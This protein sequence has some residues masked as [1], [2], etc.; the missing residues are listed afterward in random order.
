MVFKGRENSD[1][2]YSIIGSDLKCSAQDPS[3]SEVDSEE[4]VIT[5]SI[6]LQSALIFTGF[7]AKSCLLIVPHN[8][9]SSDICLQ[10][11]SSEGCIKIESGVYIHTKKTF[12]SLEVQDKM[13]ETVEDIQNI[14]EKLRPCVIADLHD[15]S[16]QFHLLAEDN[17]GS[18]KTEFQMQHSSKNCKLHAFYQRAL[19]RFNFRT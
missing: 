18:I 6:T 16:S 9:T 10:I 15:K 2:K 1:L 11:C 13:Q 4:F 19:T 8:M 7:P 17:R 3:R 5:S 12:Q 14:L